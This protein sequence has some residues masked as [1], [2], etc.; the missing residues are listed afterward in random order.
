V[1]LLA[2]LNA[3]IRSL[4]HDRAAESDDVDL[5]EDPEAAYEP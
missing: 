4:L 5:V 1:P 2:A 3:G